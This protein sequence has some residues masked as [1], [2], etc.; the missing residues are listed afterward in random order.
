WPIHTLSVETNPNHLRPDV[1]DALQ[2]AGLDRLSVGVQ[3]FD[4]A[5]LRAMKRH[6]PYGGGAQIA[7]RLA[8]S[9][10]ASRRSTST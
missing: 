4:D 5:L 10:A 6:E 8:A 3:S 1:L 9:G 7:A 2:S